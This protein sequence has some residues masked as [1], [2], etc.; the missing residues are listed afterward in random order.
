M[1][2]TR[3]LLLACA[4]LALSA[5]P[6]SAETT[7]RV[8]MH[9]DLKIVDP[10]WT[11]AYIARNHGYMIYDTLF[12]MDAKGD[13]RP[14]MV[15]KFELSPDKLTYTMTLRDG[16]VWHDGK[17]VTAEDCVASIK[18]WAAKDSLGQKMFSFVKE[19]QVVNP[20]T[21]KIVLKEQTG[22]VLP[23][24]G[25]PSSNV[26]FMMPKRVADTDPNTQISDFTGSGPF[27]FQK[28]EWKPGDKAVYVKFA[29][30]KPRPE[31]PSGLAGGK[32]AKV[33]R[34]EW[35]AIPDHQT[36]INALLANEIDLVESPPHDLYPI[37][38]KDPNVRLVNL[39][40]L[41]N[42]YVFRFNTLA[43]PF[44]N[45]K[46]RQAVWY[47]FNQKDFLE[48]V[49]GDPQYYKV[50]KA[51]FVCGTPLESTKGMDGLLESNF[52]KSK[53]LLK[54]AG[55]DGTPIVL[56][57]STDLAVL[58]NL[59]PVA[60]NL[61]EKGGFKVDMQSMDW[62]TLVARRAKKDPPD[63]GGWH[64]F[65]TSWVAADILNPVMAGFF[66][67]GCDK[68]MFGWPCD[69]E[70]ESLRDHY[71]RETD[72]AKLKPIAEAVQVRVTQYPTH[73][74]LGQWYGAA[75]VRKN[76]EGMIE[77]PVTVFWNVEKK[78]R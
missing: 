65:L 3:L 48:A 61:L 14:Q 36:A 20:K 38:R 71:A 39:N 33:D 32:V 12:A 10:I 7:L 28:D 25:K 31:P 62:Q 17:P 67:A 35:R 8:V 21:F 64:A 63:K 47:A 2:P 70:I 41:G 59:A 55:Y 42:Q 68:A 22:L 78:G 77:S 1:R 69:K 49:I 11:T 53:A 5:A 26:P 46:V 58:N 76:V 66:N 27:V 29:Q 45:A 73:I 9:S 15:D 72:P 6:A 24:L 50:C 56:M 4:A 52:E 57:H 51:M 75:A 34:V 30:Y 60:K 18:R 37:L 13:I 54:E 19:L 23:A 43:K 40:P 74:H 44:D 16:L